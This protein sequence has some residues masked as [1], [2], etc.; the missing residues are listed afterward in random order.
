MSMT[1]RAKMI[2]AGI[3]LAATVI[4]VGLARSGDQSSVGHPASPPYLTIFM[5]DG[6]SLAI[7]QKELAAG[8]LPNIRRLIDEGTYA[9]HG[10]VAFPSMTGYGFY[11][12]LT[13]RDATESGVLGLRWFDRSRDR[14]VFRNYVGR[15]NVEM[16]G[17]LRPEPLTL[18]ERFGGVHS[19]AIN[20]Y[21][22]RGASRKISTPLPFA[23]AKYRGRSWIADALTSIPLLGDRLFP[24]W[25]GVERRSVDI[26]LEDLVNRPKVQWITFVSPDTY[27]HVHGLGPTYPTL[28]HMIDEMVGRYREGAARLSLE[29]DRLYAFVSDHGVEA[30]PR[31]ID[32]R[33]PLEE[34]GLRTFR[35]DATELF[36]SRTDETF[37]AFADYDAILAING[38]LAAHVYVRDRRGWGV[39]PDLSEMRR[40][41]IVDALLASPGV[42]HVFARSDSGIVVFRRGGHGVI[43]AGDS[44]YVYRFEGADPLRYDFDARERTPGRWLEATHDREYPY[45]VVRIAHLMETEGA[46]DLVVTSARGY[47]LARDYEMIVGTYLGGHGGLRRAQLVVPL[48][49]A[50]PGVPRDTVD[51]MTVEDFG[52][53]MIERLA[54]E[55]IGSDTT[56]ATS[57]STPAQLS[58]ANQSIGVRPRARP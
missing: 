38:N 48:I 55:P 13:G 3:V 36:R 39:R 6:L 34:I 7:F 8:S 16:E 25:H 42:E 18:F 35:G 26:A 31:S 37:E 22:A 27:A 46:G 45:A 33:V 23:I 56:R 21:V 28:L 47:D 15:T 5:V 50:G 20:S 11:P 17:D 58:H 57:R 12:F 24:D 53:L 19:L 29:E 43:T 1:R 14:G 54:T 52:K 4:V 30:T 44:G 10:I 49:L 51:A 2:L 40:M 9:R 32:L 41:G